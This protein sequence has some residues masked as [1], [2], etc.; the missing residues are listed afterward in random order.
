MQRAKDQMAGLRRRESETNRLQISPFA[1]QNKIGVFSQSRTKS[2]IKALPIPM[3]FALIHWTFLTLVDEFDR[4]FN[5]QNMFV[6]CVADVIHHGSKG[7][8][9]TR[10]G[11]PCYRTSPRGTS[12]I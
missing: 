4:I 2:F 10:A 5:G 9:L 8:A 3:H 6:F 11:R 12:A 1:H 7:R